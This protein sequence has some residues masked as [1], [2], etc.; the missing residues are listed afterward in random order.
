MNQPIISDQLRAE[1]RQIV[2]EEIERVYW[3]DLK[4]TY[5]ELIKMLEKEFPYLQSGSSERK[6]KGD[7]KRLET[8]HA[9]KEKLIN[10]FAQA[11]N[12]LTYAD[13]KEI[14]DEVHEKILDSLK[15]SLPEDEQ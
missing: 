1:I 12:G 6:T 8:K 13:A 2:R 9:E 10:D 4:A 15:V 14:L 5:P 7:E 3:N 11:L